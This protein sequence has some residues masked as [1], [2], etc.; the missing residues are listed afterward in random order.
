MIQSLSPDILACIFSWLTSEELL[1][2]SSVCKQWKR[3]SEQDYLWSNRVTE[4]IVPSTL[5][6][7]FVFQR[8]LSPD[9]FTIRASEN[10][11]WFITPTLID[12]CKRTDLIVCSNGQQKLYVCNYNILYTTSLAHK[13]ICSMTWIKSLDLGDLKLGSIPDQVATMIW[14]ESLNVS[15]NRLVEIDSLFNLV[16]LTRL[17]C[18]SNS[19]QHLP[20]KLLPRLTKLTWFNCSKNVILKIPS[21]IGYLVNLTQLY[22]DYNPIHTI[23]PEIKHLS[24][25][26]G[27]SLASN[28]IDDIPVEIYELKN[29]GVLD[30]K[31]NN[32]KYIHQ[33]EIESMNKMLRLL[34]VYLSWSRMDDKS[35]KMIRKYDTRR[36]IKLL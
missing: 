36:V 2:I 4:I 6:R 9:N 14:L 26:V 28:F 11:D 35:R 8:L 13:S 21:Q 27:L 3:V 15:G 10:T 16:N 24:K 31:N 22:M 17:D 20:E 33:C 32:L 18:S 12:L 1:C 19:I 34:I 7:N 23:P 30:L 25:L 29:L 5:K